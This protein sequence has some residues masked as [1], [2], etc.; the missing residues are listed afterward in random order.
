MEYYF[1][2]SAGNSAYSVKTHEL[3]R[4]VSA[5]VI[6]SSDWTD[7]YTLWS[8]QPGLRMIRSQEPSPYITRLRICDNLQDGQNITIVLPLT[9]IILA[10]K[11][12]SKGTEV[13]PTPASLPIRTP[14]LSLPCLSTQAS[15]SSVINTYKIRIPL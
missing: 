9:C 5:E 12:L 3:R 15:K 4:H 6:Q 13:V 14:Q 11:P 1:R 2:L 7:I 8:Y 10:F